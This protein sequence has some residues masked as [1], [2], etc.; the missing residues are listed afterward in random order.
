MK[1]TYYFRIR[2]NLGMK[3]NFRI[4]FYFSIK[5]SLEKTLNSTLL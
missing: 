5:L 2:F 1:L 4:R 3:P